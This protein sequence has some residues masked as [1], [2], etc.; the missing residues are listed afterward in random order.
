MTLQCRTCGNVIYNINAKNLFLTENADV[1]MN[2]A[3]VAGTAL[4]KCP[5]LPS[6]ICG[7]CLLDLKQAV[8]RMKVFRDRCI[9]TQEQLLKSQTLVENSSKGDMVFKSDYNINQETMS[10]YEELPIEIDRL[11]EDFNDDGD[12]IIDSFEDSISN[13]AEDAEDASVQSTT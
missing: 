3:I 13:F 11:K 10:N 4:K 9:K 12:E 1:L 2:I 6:H 8:V 7:C 5:Q